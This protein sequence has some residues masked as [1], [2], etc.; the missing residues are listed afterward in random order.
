M[1]CCP[2]PPSDHI[3]VTYPRRHRPCQALTCCDRPAAHHDGP[4]HT[5]KHCPC[6]DF[7][8]GETVTEPTFQNVELPR[9]RFGRPMVMPPSGK[10]KRIPYRR[11]TTF[12]GCLDDMNGLLLSLIHI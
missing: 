12:V 9:D 11:C 1:S 2:H 3:T 7:A 6:N 5:P 4:G 10:G 8:P